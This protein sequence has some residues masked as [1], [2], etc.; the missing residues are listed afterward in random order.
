MLHFHLAI[1]I[2][3][4]NRNECF[5]EV[6]LTLPRI[7]ILKFTVWV[8]L[9]IMNVQLCMSSRIR[10]RLNFFK[11]IVTFIEQ[12]IVFITHFSQIVRARSSTKIYSFLFS[13]NPLNRV[14]LNKRVALTFMKLHLNI[15]NRF[16]TKCV[17][18]AH[19]IVMKLVYGIFGQEKNDFPIIC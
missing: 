12:P 9:R 13:P 17:K 5:E 8:I 4:N 18:R 2:I 16:V 15:V 11:F 6:Y 19:F 14:R 10:S 7:G 1:E 3:N